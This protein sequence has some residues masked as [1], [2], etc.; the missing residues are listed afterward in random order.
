MRKL[1]TL[2][3]VAVLAWTTIIGSASASSVVTLKEI[4]NRKPGELVTITGETDLPSLTLKVL[5]PNQ[6]VLYINVINGGSFSDAFILPGDS[7]A[8]TYTVIAGSGEATAVQ[9]FEVAEGG[10]TVIPV[11]SIRVSPQNPSVTI[12]SVTSFTAT[13][14]PADATNKNVSWSVENG[15]GRASINP[16]GALTAGQ[17]GTVTVKAA[18]LDGSGIV[19]TSV[20]TILQNSGNGGDGSGGGNGNAGPGSNSGN[21]ET[22]V[23]PVI[24]DGVAT[25]TLEANQTTATVVVSELQGLPL[26]VT[27]SEVTLTIEPSEVSALLKQAGNAD[28]A[29]LRVKISPVTSGGVGSVTQQGSAKL[30]TSGEVYD[31]TVTL[32]T[33]DGTEIRAVK[34]EG[35]VEIS[36]PYDPKRTDEMLLGIYY[37]NEETGQWEYVGGIL[38]K[39]GERI[40][41]RLKH[42]SQYAVMEYRKAFADVGSSHWAARTLE[43]LA[44]RQIVTGQTDTLFKPSD[45]TTRA[46]F[47]AMLVR[48]LDLPAAT[49]RSSFADVK[50]NAWYSAAVQSAHAAGLITGLSDTQFGPDVTITREQ[51]AVLLV[52]AYEVKQGKINDSQEPLNAFKDREEISGW[53]KGDVNKALAAKLMQG[54]GNGIFD[55]KSPATRAQNAQAIFNLITILTP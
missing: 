21:K 13:V 38:D 32:V 4:Q 11:S 50:E 48:V 45:K 3:F 23:K 15:S 10:S 20:V 43:V 54:V 22:P 41:A 2:L 18:A 12:G 19:A 47:T 24:K 7:T 1:C 28:G 35:E 49:S 42:L 6:S 40:K 36:L 8:G 30:T 51:I 44:A 27:L 31:L 17:P 55:S 29:L 46:E 14:L 16:Q 26:Q 34:L 39:K 25:V 33:K 5:R 37:H 52:R 53:A 9:K